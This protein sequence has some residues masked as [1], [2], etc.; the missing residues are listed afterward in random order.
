MNSQ[1]N[2][3][4]KKLL[5]DNAAHGLLDEL[6][7]KDHF[8]LSKYFIDKGTRKTNLTDIQY[9]VLSQFLNRDY[10]KLC[11][12]LSERGVSNNWSSLKS[13]INHLIKRIP[14]FKDFDGFIDNCEQFKNTV[15]EV[16]D[17]QKA[18][19]EAEAKAKAEAAF[20][21]FRNE[22][23][24]QISK[25]TLPQLRAHRPKVERIEEKS[26][27]HKQLKNELLK[28]I[29]SR[30][31]ELESKLKEENKKA[32]LARTEEIHRKREEESAR[33]LAERERKAKEAI[34]ERKKQEIEDRE[35]DVNEFFEKQNRKAIYAENLRQFKAKIEKMPLSKLKEQKSQLEK[36][37]GA[38]DDDAKF[39]ADQL[40]EL[41]YWIGTREREEKNRLEEERLKADEEQRAIKKK[42]EE[43]KRIQ[44][45]RKAKEEK[46]KAEEEERKR[47]ELSKMSFD[48]IKK[49]K[50]RFANDDND[51]KDPEKLFILMR[52]YNEKMNEERE[53]E[54]AEQ[55]RK[56]AELKRKRA[57]DEKQIDKEFEKMNR[58]LTELEDDDAEY[59]R[60]KAD[61]F[62]ND[63]LKE[64][65]LKATAKAAEEKATKENTQLEAELKEKQAEQ[66]K[67][68]NELKKA[69][70]IKNRAATRLVNSQS[71][72]KHAEYALKE[73]ERKDADDAKAR[74]KIKELE[75]KLKEMKNEEEAAKAEAEKVDSLKKQ[76]AKKAEEELEKIEQMKKEVNE[77]EQEQEKAKLK[78]QAWRDKVSK[79]DDNKLKEK[80]SKYSKIGGERYSYLSD[81]SRERARAKEEEMKQ[82]FQKQFESNLVE[83]EKTVDTIVREGYER[84]GQTAA[85]RKKTISKMIRNW[86]TNSKNKEY[87]VTPAMR[88]LNREYIISKVNELLKPI[89][90]TC[91]ISDGKFNISV[92]E[93]NKQKYADQVGKVLSAGT[94]LNTFFSYDIN[95][96][97]SIIEDFIR[98][99]INS[100]YTMSNEAKMNINALMNNET[101]F[102]SHPIKTLANE[103]HGVQINSKF[104][105][106][107][108][109]QIDE[110]INSKMNKQLIAQSKALSPDEK[111]QLLKKFHLKP[112]TKA[113]LEEILLRDTASLKIET[114][115]E[116]KQSL[117]ERIKGFKL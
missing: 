73:A 111:L 19:A 42:E 75:P 29:D 16:K 48:E 60:K 114:K 49:E 46:A 106:E 96:V 94:D 71:R 103:S 81:I 80:L 25:F 7:K 87:Y 110:Y 101:K 20:N 14:E 70:K 34:E 43:E 97:Y 50:N 2:E 77:L 24:E 59:K 9:K 104:I 54:R 89:N 3:I 33:I 100:K 26:D 52:L 17:S 98:A 65:A 67:L 41:D 85:E 37:N 93:F 108:A 58:S 21:N 83:I 113:K 10:D 95:H 88:K 6:A 22:Q 47:A 39:I 4:V 12:T 92:S 61:K 76:I 56:Q 90:S 44:A 72:L 102:L 78:E 116:K 8:N 69:E 86:I 68:K 1:Q 38:T 53:R 40:R 11:T 32:S 99:R 31:E 36:V 55:E 107:L 18:K 117:T 35:K 28:A 105:N 84:W 64:K 109:K 74:E 30:I 13:L 63:K 115:K 91:S 27:K 66:D 62:H 5:G 82:A 112:S 51:N 79:L 45:E 57:E 15:E 23:L